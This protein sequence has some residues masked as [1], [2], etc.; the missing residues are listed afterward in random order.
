MRLASDTSS[1][2]IY[3]SVTETTHRGRDHTHRHTL[4]ATHTNTPSQSHT[5]TDHTEPNTQ[6]AV[7]L[8]NLLQ[9]AEITVLSTDVTCQRLCYIDVGFFDIDVKQVEYEA[10]QRGAETVAEAANTSD[11][12]LCNTCYTHILFHR[13]IA[14]HKYLP[15]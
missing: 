2:R 7:N 4:R 3:K 10:K 15:T 14:A 12:S 6:R 11:H 13:P 5:H 8:V 9:Y 1:Y